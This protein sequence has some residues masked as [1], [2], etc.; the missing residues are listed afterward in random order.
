MKQLICF[1]TL[2][3]IVLGCEHDDHNA[4]TRPEETYTNSIGMK[5]IYIPPG[6]FMMG[7][8]DGDSDEKPIH[9]VYISRGFYLS[10]TEVTQAQYKAVMGENPSYFKGDNNPVEQ[11]NWYD[12]NDF[13]KILSQKEGKTYTLPT[14]AEWEYSCRAGT[15]TRYSFGDSESSLD[16]YAWYTSNSYDK[17]H[18]VGLKKPNAFGLYDM[19]GNVWEWCRDG[20]DPGYYNRGTIM[21]PEVW[22]NNESRVLRGGCWANDASACRSMLRFWDD[23]DA[24]F[25]D[26]GFRVVMSVSSQNF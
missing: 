1:F 11:V 21:D 17:T 3:F 10:T 19:H 24:K 2:L 8:K 12:A 18:P 25:I 14:E 6:D 23:S 4:Q 16:D 26:Y 22:P 15:S 9:K 7:S 5:L 13:C 20:Y